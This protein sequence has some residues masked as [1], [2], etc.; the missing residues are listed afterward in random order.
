MNRG[1]I[2][3]VMLPVPPPQN[4]GTPTAP[5]THVQFGSRPCVIVQH[6]GS[7]ANLSTVLI[8]PITGNQRHTFPHS[9]QVQPSPQNGLDRPSTILTHQLRTADKAAVGKRLGRLE[10]AIMRQLETELKA[11]LDL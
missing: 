1:D 2:H 8:V 9:L 6:G 10:A 4:L 11:I 5:P 7:T 3:F